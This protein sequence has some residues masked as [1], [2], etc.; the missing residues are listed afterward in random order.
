MKEK[1]SFSHLS[2]YEREQLF[3]YKQQGKCLREIGRL[4]DR[5]HSVISRELKRNS[6]PHEHM[7]GYIGTLAHQQAKDRKK[8]SGKRP[9][10]KH[11][12]LQK[13]VQEKMKIGWTPEIIASQVSVVFQGFSI[14][15]EAIYQ[16]VYA[17]WPEGIIS[18]LKTKSYFCKPYHSWEKGAIENTNGLIRRFIPKKTDLANFS[19]EQFDQIEYLLNHRPRKCLGFKTPYQVFLKRTGAIPP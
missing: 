1:R 2:L 8:N 15:H 11:A 7:R 18:V 13:Y 19:Q 5:D 3:V 6:N 16:Y 17:Q 9:R 14:S 12:D 4:L 10:L